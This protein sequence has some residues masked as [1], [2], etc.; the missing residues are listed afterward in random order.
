MSDRNLSP[1]LMGGRVVRSEY[2]QFSETT[3]WYLPLSEPRSYVKRHLRMGHSHTC[4][5]QCITE[6]LMLAAL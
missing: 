3:Y 4:I 6:G 1:S 2:G 5:L